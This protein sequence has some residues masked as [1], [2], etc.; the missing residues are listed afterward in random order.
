MTDDP[1]QIYRQIDLKSRVDAASPHQLVALLLEGLLG[2]LYESV[3]ALQNRDLEAKSR[4]ISKA[5]GIINALRES[6]NTELDSEL[7]HNLDRLYDYMQR[8]LLDAS[9]LLDD[10]PVQEV[11]DL[12]QVL[13]SGW[14]EI[15]PQ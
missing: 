7:P 15:A 11:I 3:G 5:I 1:L 6:L 4:L 14:D 13:K 10:T 2:A 12:V 9:G 8:R